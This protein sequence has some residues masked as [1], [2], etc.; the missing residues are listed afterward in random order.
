MV[1][2]TVAGQQRRCRDWVTEWAGTDSK[3]CLEVGVG[4]GVGQ[5]GAG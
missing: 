1:V 5:K 4:R 2:A 3:R